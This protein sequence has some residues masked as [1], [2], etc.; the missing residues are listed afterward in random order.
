MNDMVAKYII[1]GTTLFLLSGVGSCTYDN[2]LSKELR[3]KELNAIVTMVKHGA[4]PVA[5][6]CALTYIRN[7]LTE[8]SFFAVRK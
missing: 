1:I 4:S 3:E 7:E 6:K 2:K 5:A 8:C